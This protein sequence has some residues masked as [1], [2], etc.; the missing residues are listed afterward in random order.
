MIPGLAF[1]QG[2]WDAGDQYRS[3]RCSGAQGNI[4]SPALEVNLAIRGC[5]RALGKQDQRVTA[6]QAFFCRQ[7]HDCGVFVGDVS[8]SFYWTTREGVAGQSAIHNA[9]GM[10]GVGNQEYYIDK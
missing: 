1:G 7:Q 4:C 8:S 6:G 2:G 3:N 10:F 5:P 9:V